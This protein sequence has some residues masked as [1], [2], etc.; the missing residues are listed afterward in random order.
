MRSA[1]GYHIEVQSVQC[2]VQKEVFLE[3]L[4]SKSQFYLCVGIPV[5]EQFPHEM[6][7]IEN[8]SFA[9]AQFDVL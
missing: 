3:H 9:I 7:C 4:V 1:I 6:G 5:L 8:R 2:L